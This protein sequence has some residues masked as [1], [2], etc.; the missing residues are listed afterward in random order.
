M[1]IKKFAK[2]IAIIFVVLLLA[3]LTAHF[4]LSVH[5]PLYFLSENMVES[6]GIYKE[7]KRE[8]YLV[9]EEDIPLLIAA[10][11]DAKVEEKT[12][13]EYHTW[14]D[15]WRVAYKVKLKT[16]QVLTVRM[17]ANNDC[18]KIGD[19][20]NKKLWCIDRRCGSF[21][22]LIEYEDDFKVRKDTQI[23]K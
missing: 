18:F 2:I 4:S 9:P 14:V 1:K 20:H 15:I 13:I 5:Q 3:L 16:G 23:F 8:F 6:I 7:H 22:I 11:K 19:K 21:D 17:T 12:K 10:M